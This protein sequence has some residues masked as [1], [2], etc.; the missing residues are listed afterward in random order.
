MI[1]AMDK[2]NQILFFFFEYVKPEYILELHFN[3]T[4]DSEKSPCQEVAR[5]R[6][7]AP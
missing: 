1:Y 6:K 3:L 4:L 7:R 5:L 2:E